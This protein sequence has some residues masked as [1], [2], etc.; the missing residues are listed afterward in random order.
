MEDTVETISSVKK[1][2]IRFKWQGGREVTLSCLV[3]DDEAIEHD[4]ITMSGLGQLD[5][6]EVEFEDETYPLCM[7]CH[8]HL[9]KPRM[10][11]RP[12]GS[13]CLEELCECTNP[14]C[15]NKA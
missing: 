15:S 1:G 2:T 6:V 8:T 11:E 12:E 3:E 5:S 7:E 13:G 10:I 9:I 14:N 4:A